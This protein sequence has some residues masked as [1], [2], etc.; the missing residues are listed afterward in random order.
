MRD[1]LGDE[2][3]GGILGFVQHME[4]FRD[5]FSEIQQAWAEAGADWNDTLNRRGEI[6]SHGCQ[7]PCWVWYDGS[8]LSGKAFCG[9]CVH[10]GLYTVHGISQRLRSGCL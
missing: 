5:A 2:I 1:L 9:F 3:G 8:A 10:L 6:I 4:E 7:Q